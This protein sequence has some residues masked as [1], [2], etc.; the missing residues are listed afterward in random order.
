MAKLVLL[1]K[2]HRSGDLVPI[3]KQ[4]TR[5]G[6]SFMQTV[7]VSPRDAVKTG[8]KMKAPD[9]GIKRSSLFIPPQR[10]NAGD[11]AKRKVDP[12][13]TPDEAG[14]NCV[15][16]S[17]GN[18]AATELKEKINWA[19]EETKQV[20]QT[21]EWYCTNKKEGKDAEYMTER[22]ALHGRIMN[23]LLSPDKIRTAKPR[24]GEKPA[25]I[26]L[27][28]RGG[29]G[30]SWF[31]DN[32]YNSKKF[33]ILDADSIKE[34]LPEYK[35]WNAYQ[36]HEESSDILE[37]MIDFCKREGLN[38]VIDM[39]MKT[40]KSAYER[41]ALFKDKGYRTEAHYM[42]L[43][44]QE[45]AKRAIKRYR[46]GDNKPGE[47]KG[48]FVPPETILKMRQNEETFDQIKELVD[49]WSFR[50]STNGFPPVLISRKSGKL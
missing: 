9:V 35:G 17:F 31:K 41:L 48:R 49:D 22:E 27:G 32:I 15:L 11:W 5:S 25:M 7:W 14:V 20:T 40:P 38:I 19:I 10:F 26:M 47:Y 16:A 1:L 4:V 23:T 2:A 45:A 34:E 30:K 6:K 28:G 18:G 46:D 8:G 12:K 24:E 3:K 44:P 50:D 42:H 33:V 21:K 39:T 37:Q 43:P 29:S 36:V 13:A